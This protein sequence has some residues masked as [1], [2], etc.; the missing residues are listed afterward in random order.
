MTQC[1]PVSDTVR[2]SRLRF[3]STWGSH[4]AHGFAHIARAQSTEDQRRAVWAA[5]QKPPLSW[6]RPPGRPNLTWLRVIADDVKPMNFGVHT[7]WRKANDRKEWRRVWAQQRSSRSRLWREREKKLGEEG[8]AKCM[9][10]SV[11]FSLR[12]SLV[13]LVQLRSLI[14]FWC[15]SL[16]MLGDTTHSRGSFFSGQICRQ[17]LAERSIHQIWN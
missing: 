6:K 5:M 2:A 9:R 1:L 10:L 13:L 12:L 14:Y 15:R 7:A 17:D 16:R 8:W 3:S 4:I 11:E